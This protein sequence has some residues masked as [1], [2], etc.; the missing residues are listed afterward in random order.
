[1]VAVEPLDEDDL[2]LEGR[3][4]WVDGWK[5]WVALGLA[6]LLVAPA[7]LGLISLIW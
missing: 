1:M 7:V 5:R 3:R 2:W 6:V 4:S